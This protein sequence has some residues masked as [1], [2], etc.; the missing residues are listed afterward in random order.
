MGHET[1]TTL[2]DFAADVRA[3]TPTAAAELAVPVRTELLAQTLDFERRM[4][5][6]FT[7]GMEDRRRHLAQLARVLPRA[8]QPVRRA[9]PA[10]STMAADKLGHALRRNLQAHRRAF[11]E[12]AALLRPRAIR[13]AS[14]FGREHDGLLPN[15]A[16]RAQR[17][18]LAEARRHL[19]VA[20]AGAGQ[21]F[22]Q[23]RAGARLCAGARRGWRG[24]PPCRRA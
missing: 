13:T 18:K 6:C 17:A 9:A 12:T 19:E 21:R 7:K 24:A 16:T 8:D 15:G 22:P 4:L 5:R 23:I 2:I 3:P 20:G 11:L 1:D 14:G 10:L